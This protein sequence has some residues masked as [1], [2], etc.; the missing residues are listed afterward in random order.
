V[1]A[2]GGGT[3]GAA[4]VFDVAADGRIALVIA[5]TVAHAL[6]PPQVATRKRFR[7]GGQ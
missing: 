3:I 6:R 4:V 1:L 5:C 2:A 7:S